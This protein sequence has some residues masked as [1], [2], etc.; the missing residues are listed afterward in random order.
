M[1]DINPVVH[2]IDDDAAMREAVCRSLS[3]FG[4]EVREYESA[5]AFLLTWPGDSPGCLLLD[6][7]MPGP[8]GMELQQALAQRAD[9]P[10]V[11]F[12][13]G[14]RRHSDERA[15]HQAWRR[16]LPHQASGP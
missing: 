8:S 7:R 16:R 5:G 14:L 9:A 11:V 13:T 12:L 2:V 6:V 3:G 15:C 10:P 1:A 4:F